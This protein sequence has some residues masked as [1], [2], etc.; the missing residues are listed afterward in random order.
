MEVERVLAPNQPHTLGGRLKTKV[1]PANQPFTP[2][3]MLKASGSC[4]YFRCRGFIGS[5]VR[6]GNLD[7]YFFL[8][9]ISPTYSLFWGLHAVGGRC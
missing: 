8:T 1:P 4:A 6:R 2:G 5:A 3:G 9:C 7:P